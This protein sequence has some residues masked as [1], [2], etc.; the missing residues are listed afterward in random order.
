MEPIL[1]KNQNGFRQGRSTLSQ[2]LCLHRLIEESQAFNKD[3][4]L[5]FV[6]LLKAFDTVDRD[7]MFEIL[8]LYGIPKKIIDAI[9]VSTLT[10]LQLY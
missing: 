2:I 4:A 10:H 9:K 5:V 6:D 8:G 3:L 1:R 7:K